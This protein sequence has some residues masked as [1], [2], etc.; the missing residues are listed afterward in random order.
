MAYIG[1]C[2]FCGKSGHLITWTLTE[3]RCG[4]CWEI[5]HWQKIKYVREDEEEQ[6]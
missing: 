4:K 2:P 3:I 1:V 6:P 5:F